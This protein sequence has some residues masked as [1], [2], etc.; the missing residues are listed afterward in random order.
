MRCV[1]QSHPRF[2]S[3]APPS[4][5]AGSP[6]GSPPRNFLLINARY[7]ISRDGSCKASG[8]SGTVQV[9]AVAGRGGVEATED[10]SC[11]KGSGIMID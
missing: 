11:E 4:M 2:L 10:R 1:I 5:E 7:P 6:D 9:H 8:G 3:R